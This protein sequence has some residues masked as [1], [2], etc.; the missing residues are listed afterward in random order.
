MDPNHIREMQDKDEDQAL[1]RFIGV[2]IALV[3]IVLAWLAFT[4]GGSPS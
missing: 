2:C 1:G 3:L 4:G